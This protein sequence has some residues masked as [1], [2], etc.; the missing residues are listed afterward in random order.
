MTL[1]RRVSIPPGAHT[2]VIASDE[3]AGHGSGWP[4]VALATPGIMSTCLIRRSEI[5]N[6]NHSSPVVYALDIDRWIIRISRVEQEVSK[7][8]C[9]LLDLGLSHRNSRHAKA[10][11]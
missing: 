2:F 11:D 10:R 1:T 6:A 3:P 5:R 4:P 8:A 9:S 7:S